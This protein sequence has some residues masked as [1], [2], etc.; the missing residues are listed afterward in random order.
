MKV[1]WQVSNP[2]IRKIPIKL[3]T[4]QGCKGLAEDYV[5]ITHFDDQYYLDARPDSKDRIISDL[6]VCK[7]IV[8]LTRARKKVFLLSSNP[9]ATPTFLNW[10]PDELIEV[11]Y[12]SGGLGGP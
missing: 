2:A 10:L 8:A 9:K 11:V 3:S 1:Q 4:V 6:N 5:F 12:E 7:L